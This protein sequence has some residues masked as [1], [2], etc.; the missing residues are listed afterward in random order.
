MTKPEAYSLQLNG[1]RLELTVMR[2]GARYRTQAAVGA[3]QAGSAYH[4]VGTYDGANARLYVNGAQVATRAL[5]GAV[6]SSSSPL[7]VGSWDGFSERFRGTVDEVAVYASAL[8][9]SRVTAHRDAAGSAPDPTVLAPND[10]KATVV[11]SSRIDLAWVDNSSNETEFVLERDT[12]SQFTSPQAVTLPQ[13]TTQ[14]SLTGLSAGTP[15]YFRVRARNATNT[16]NWSS[17]TTATTLTTTPPPPPAGYADAVL[18]DAPVSH[19]RLGD[20]GTTAADAKAANPGTYFNGAATGSASLL[21][22]DLGNA[23]V[24]F[25]GVNDHVRVPNSVSLGLSAP[26]TLEAWIKPSSIP[27]AGRF[28][29]IVTKPESYSLQFNGPRLEFTIMQ[30]GVRQRLQAPLGAIQAGQAYHVVGTYDGATRRLYVN[31]VQVASAALTG[32]ATASS[33]GLF[34]GSWSG[35]SEFFAGTIDEVAVYASA[36]SASRVAAHRAAGQ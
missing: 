21:P 29:S 22:G 23:A 3:I 1:P 4:V 17:P 15:Y 34:I 16:S 5:T 26:L 31:G 8:P 18:A 35:T 12:A 11:S 30:F 19:W 20:A 32:G 2:G 28:R 13:N 27:A 7:N 10:L 25:D 6:G 14:H 9:A 36:L 33:Q 24:A